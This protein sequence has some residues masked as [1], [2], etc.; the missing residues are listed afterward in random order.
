MI[1]PI[2]VLLA[3]YNGSAF[4]AEQLDSLI[5][6]TDPGWRLLVR[7]D[8]STDRTAEIVA[9]YAAKDARITVLA[10]S[11]TNQ[12]T[13]ANF[14]RLLRAA[15]EQG[16]A[17]VML[18][19]Q[20]DVW[21]ADKIERQIR[22]MRTEEERL[23]AGVPILVHSDLELIDC[24]GRTIHSSFMNFQHIRDEPSAP[25]RTLL[26]Q[27]YVTGCTILVNRP[28]LDAALPIP[29]S[30]MVHD[31]W[32]ALIAAT[33]GKILYD[34]TPT[35]GYRQHPGNQIG[36]K[37][38]R[39]GLASVWQGLRLSRTGDGNFARSLAQASALKTRV[40]RAGLGADAQQ[41]LLAAYCALF[42]R[43]RGRCARISGLRALGLRRQWAVR[44]WLLYLHACLLPAAYAN[45]AAGK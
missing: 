39:R 42:E 43:P 29:P 44:Q 17:Y 1:K 13:A 9:A 25:L 6:Q 30:A 12:G 4:I 22:L 3:T 5:A 11:Q 36:A 45:P 8:A 31:W 19:D 40:E 34:P 32:L 24:D 2:Y 21:R 38:W 15:C 41:Q 28:L 14:G 16:A 27:N 23:G 10:A 37:G 35:V 18:M 20:D 33:V 7:D 26:V